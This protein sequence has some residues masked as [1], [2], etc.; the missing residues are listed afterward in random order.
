MEAVPGPEDS[1]NLVPYHPE[2]PSVPMAHADHSTISSDHTLMMSEVPLTTDSAGP[3]LKL[4]HWNVLEEDEYNG[5]SHPGNTKYGETGP[6]KGA[7]HQRIADDRHGGDS[8]PLVAL[9]SPDDDW[10]GSRFDWCRSYNYRLT[11]GRHPLAPA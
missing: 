2:L 11:A 8:A 7:R 4:L 3:K 5:F 9:R 1:Q 6:Q 10:I